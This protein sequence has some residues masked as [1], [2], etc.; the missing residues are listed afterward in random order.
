[1][2]NLIVQAIHTLNNRIEA[3]CSFHHVI[4]NITLHVTPKE[5]GEPFI[6]YVPINGIWGMTIS[7]EF[8]KLE[9]SE[10]IQAIKDKTIEYFKE[11]KNE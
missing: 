8:G 6:S 11:L 1:M 4:L 9:E 3:Q 5:H 7:R 2:Q 10:I